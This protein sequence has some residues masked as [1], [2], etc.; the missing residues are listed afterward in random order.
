MAVLHRA[1]FTWF[2]LLVF[3]VLLVLR[4]DSRIQWNWFIVFIPL[5]FYDSILMIYVFFNM[6]SYCR[7]SVDRLPNSVQRKLWYLLAILLKLISIIILCLKL[8][9]IISN[10]PTVYIMIPIWI[11]MPFMISDVFMSLI[12]SSRNRFV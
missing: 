11:L 12:K 7:N 4:L 9:N 3:L 2:V 1:L 6:M 10:I 8:E 5:W